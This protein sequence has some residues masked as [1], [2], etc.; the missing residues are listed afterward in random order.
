MKARRQL[1]DGGI[2]ATIVGGQVSQAP[3]H[4]RAA[5]DVEDLPSTSVT[6]TLTRPRPLFPSTCATSPTIRVP[7]R[8]T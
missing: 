5:F 7:R 2:V 4:A 8:I 3:R 1:D 6:L